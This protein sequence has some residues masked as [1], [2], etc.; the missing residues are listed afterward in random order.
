MKKRLKVA[1]VY[2]EADA[3]IYKK[4]DD[5]LIKEQDF[6]PYFEIDDLTPME[7]YEIISRKLKRIGFSSYTLNIKDDKIG[8]AHV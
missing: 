8:R 5:E 6:V 7:E 2:N 1:V 4:I 3:N